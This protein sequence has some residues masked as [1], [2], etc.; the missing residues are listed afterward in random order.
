MGNVGENSALVVHSSVGHG[1]GG[2]QQC[3]KESGRPDIAGAL[4]Q[5]TGVAGR[6]GQGGDHAEQ[7]D[8]RQSLCGVCSRAGGKQGDVLPCHKQDDAASVQQDGQQIPLDPLQAL[9]IGIDADGDAADQVVQ[10][11]DG[12]IVEDGRQDRRLK[13]LECKDPRRKS[14]LK[15]A[16]TANTSP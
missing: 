7:Q 2:H 3:V 6:N 14:V 13:G 4:V 16:S 11:E 9:G 10:E 5:C 1:H 15:M 8:R 12:Q